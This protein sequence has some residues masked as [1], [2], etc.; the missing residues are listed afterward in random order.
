MFPDQPG[1]PE[2]LDV[3]GALLCLAE[4]IAGHT[5]LDTLLPMIVELV[6]TVV[7][8]HCCLLSLWDDNRVC[9]VPA[10]AR[11]LPPRLE[12]LFHRLPIAPGD[13][14]LV[15]EVVR[16]RRP[17]LADLHDPL[18]AA[19][20]RRRWGDSLANTEAAILG[21]PLLHHDQVLGGMALL[22]Q[23]GP[24]G[25]G[26]R[27]VALVNGIARQTA[28]A[29]ASAYAFEA[30]HR[31]RRD[32]EALRETIALLTVEL[33]LE[34]LYRC[35]AERAAVTFAAPAAA[36]FLWDDTSD[37]LPPRATY[38]LSTN[39][40]QRQRVSSDLMHDLLRAHPDARPFALPDLRLTPLGNP[41][42]IRAEGLRA[43]LVIPLQ[44]GERLWG[45]IEVYERAEPATFDDDALALARAL[46][47][48]IVIALENARLYQQAQERSHQLAEVLAAGYEVRVNQD[49]AAVL[50]RIA[51]GIQQGLGWQAVLITRYDSITG[52]ACADVCVGFPQGTLDRL[53]HWG[54]LERL[55]ALYAHEQYRIGRS[56]FVPAERGG[57]LFAREFTAQVA[58]GNAH[59]SVEQRP[60][61]STRPRRGWQANDMLFVPIQDRHGNVLGV[62]SVDSPRH[63][64][65]P[66]LA[67]VQALEIFADQAATAIENA[68]LYVALRA[69]RERLRALSA[70]LAQAQEAE[71]TRI[72]RE[73]HDEAGQAL[74]T[75]RLQ[76]DFIS[77]VLPPDLPPHVRQQVDEAYA[78]V[79][80]TLEEIRRISLDLRP[81]LLDDL[82]LTPALRWQCRQLNRRAGLKVCLES[83]GDERRLGPDVE[84][85]VYRVIQEALTNIV[86]H[87]QATEATISLDY[88]RERLRL[89]V[90]DN[91]GG[92]PDV[93]A[94]GMGLGLLGMRERITA[95]DG[96][97]RIQSLPGAGST[98]QIEVP[99]S[100]E[101][102]L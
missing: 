15:D 53:Y 30:E 93:A 50:Q 32:L 21:V 86:R 69:E 28:L 9:F 45:L 61:R 42:L 89:V 73:L 96:T 26:P 87:A 5:C 37:S 43:A 63:G 35:V 84:T 34:T 10:V 88:Q 66:Q 83:T 44:R 71:R 6:S 41:D 55:W 46:G 97:L 2:G 33:E 22:H 98:L 102:G 12:R 19:P 100:G 40:V 24:A 74:T 75:V 23:Q 31:R 52:R 18:I 59:I 95:V 16:R 81:S 48:Q 51:A 76:L 82:G 1:T 14:P 7:G 58:S 90:T 39:Y 20:L 56:Y 92:F 85:A 72:A 64:R 80:R 8:C 68:Q 36:L 60:V 4:T 38:G 49:T 77:S 25:F 99:L 67:D 79:G 54:Q 17:I 62:V 3:N 47:H 65:R 78:L 70:Q 101:K 29:V 91:G 27:E 11:G 13:I 94:Q 57:S